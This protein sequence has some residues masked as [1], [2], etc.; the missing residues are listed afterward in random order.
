MTSTSENPVKG[1]EPTSKPTLCGLKGF[2]VFN[3]KE[4]KLIFT[5]ETISLHISIALTV[6]HAFDASIVSINN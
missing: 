1:W 6:L 2:S 4:F 3:F 5:T